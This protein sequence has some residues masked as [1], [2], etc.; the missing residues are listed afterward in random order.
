MKKVLLWITRDVSLKSETCHYKTKFGR[1]N[2][3]ILIR[4]ALNLL[5]SLAFSHSKRIYRE[6]GLQPGSMPS[7]Q[8]LGLPSHFSL[9]ALLCQN[10][11]WG[12]PPATAASI[13]PK[14]GGYMRNTHSLGLYHGLHLRSSKDTMHPSHHRFTSSQPLKAT[15]SPLK[16][17]RRLYLVFR[18]TRIDGVAWRRS[19]C[20]R[21]RKTDMWK[22]SLVLG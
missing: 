8:P 21:E 20:H 16:P 14:V 12:H 13:I 15:L 6:P 7:S 22:G 11:L 1:R 4:K 9:A 18:K 3:F 17:S 19:P 10:T 2:F 5:K